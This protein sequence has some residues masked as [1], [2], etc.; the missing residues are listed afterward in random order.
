[1]VSTRGIANVGQGGLLY[2]YTDDIIN[3]RYRE[4]LRREI[5]KAA[6][7][8]LESQRRFD[9]G[10]WK[11]ILE[12][13]LAIHP[14]FE[15]RVHFQVGKDLTGFENTDIPY[16]MGDYMPVFQVDENDNLVR[17]YDE[18]QGRLLPLYDEKGRPTDVQVYDKAGK[19]L[20]RVDKEGKPLPIPLFD[21]EGKRIPIFDKNGKPI[22][23]LVIYKIEANPGAGLW[24]PHNDQLPPYRKG[25]GVYTVFRCLGERA[26]IYREKLEEIAKQRGV[27]HPPSP[28]PSTYLPSAPA[29]T[30]TVV[31]SL[32]EAMRKA[33]EELGKGGR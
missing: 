5:T 18:E 31:S 6:F 7:N 8:S 12:D 10:H 24:R 2:E 3:P 17:L 22:S 14:E 33:R 25:E 1:V 11:E 30:E 13:Y 15:D 20:P 29:E 19:P 4:D 16:E 32:D 26:S 23:T 27:P 9:K 21:K 28:P